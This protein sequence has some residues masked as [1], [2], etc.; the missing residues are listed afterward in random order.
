MSPPRVGTLCVVLHTHLP[1]LAG[2]GTWPV[3]EEWL[4]QAWSASYLPLVEVLHDLAEEGRTDLVSLGL[5]PVLAAQ[6]DDPWCLREHHAWLARWRLRAEELAAGT[7]DPRLREAAAREWRAAAGATTVFEQRWLHGGSAALRPLVDAGAVELLGGPATH[8]VLPLLP[9][10]LAGAAVAAGLDDAAVRL[11]RRPRGLWAPECAV[12]PGLQDVLAREGVSHLMVEEATLLAAGRGTDRLWSWGGVLVAGRD[13]ALTDRVWSSRAGY[14]SGPD[15]QDFH[16]LDE[17]SGFRVWRVTDPTR[18]DKA[19]YDPDRAAAAVH[20]D[21]A[22]FAAT[23]RDRLVDRH[24]RGEEPLAVVAWDTEL[25][26]HWWHEGPQFLA[27]ALRMLPEAG[28]R[29]ATLG[30]VAAEQADRAPE[31]E[32]SLG[33]WGHGKGLRLWA[34]PA[35]ADLRADQQAVAA[36]LLSAVRPSA[37]QGA[38]R[39]HRLDAMT[40]EA[41]LLHASDWAFMVSRDSAA[42]YA[43]DRHQGH[44]R[45]FRDL[46]AEQPAA[47]TRVPNVVVP[48]LDARGLAA[49]LV[50][51]EA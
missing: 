19:P 14:P 29:V 17:G 40:R 33:S 34:G 35:V 24:R 22:A 15:Y 8:P 26:G 12:A 39:D 27:Q 51:D 50:A 11:G 47:T 38:H 30:R 21:A 10:R 16:H 3:G 2:H 45:A 6:L 23:V 32:L 13:L 31:V 9:D 44:L 36:E 25:F 42:G 37:R 20:R 7:R 43:R 41:L 18:P 46:A 5:T 28:V 48:H 49:G 1:W 4:H